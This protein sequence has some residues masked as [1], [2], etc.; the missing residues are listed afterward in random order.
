MNLPST[1]KFLKDVYI[2][3]MALVRQKLPGPKIDHVCETVRDE[4]R[5]SVLPSKLRDGM[6]VA[7]SCGSR[8]I[9][10]I[11]EIIRE[12]SDFCKSYGAEPFIV[13][14][15]GSHGGATGEGQV[16]VLRSLGVTEKFC[17]CP[18]RS[19]METVRLGTTSEGYPIYLDRYASQADGIIV[20][21]RVKAHT[22]FRGEYESGLMK[23][24]AVGLGKRDGAQVC[25]MTGFRL[26]HTIMPSVANGILQHANILLGMAI[27]ENAYD[28]TCILRALAPQEIPLE[29]P[30]L[31][32][33]A[34][35]LMGRIYL[36][37]TDLLIIDRI[38]KNISGDG[39][40]PN[41]AGN[42]CCPYASGGLKAEKRIVLDL[43]DETHGNAMGIGLY[44]AT[45][46]RLFDKIDFD[47]TYVNP[48][49]SSAINMAK[50]PMIMNSD[51]DA[52]AACL[53]STPEIDHTNPRIIRIKDSAHIDEIYVSKAHYAE[54][55][56][57][58]R[59]E[60]LTPFVPMEFS[61]EGNLW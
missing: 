57:D 26:M 33:Q 53:K 3:P 40:D 58:P 13:P 15:M 59:M 25:H 5:N 30:K 16:E 10:N 41:I 51:H 21:G 14:A 6:S 28:E 61:S 49:V 17:G 45:T 19:S 56:A 54:V 22:A 60:L 20:V 4:L 36:P 9:T 50:V 48:L 18:I 37:E 52:I 39:S 32:V 46:Q 47:V 1:S 29:E 35:E 31:L 7:I 34:K 38:G 23:M 55:L 12:I 43:T 27:I 44:D 2:P 8:G 24:M 42:F 11:A